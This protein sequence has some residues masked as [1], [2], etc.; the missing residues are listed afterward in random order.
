MEATRFDLEGE[1]AIVTGGGR[2]IGRAC[3]LALSANGANVVVASRTRAEIE[4]V[5]RQ[6]KNEGRESLAVATDVTRKEDVEHLVRR[7]MAEFGAIDILVNNAGIIIVKPIVPTP[8]W[9]PPLA[10]LVSNFNDGFD[11]QDWYRILETN[12]TSIFRCC[13]AVVPHMMAKK[14][15]RIINISSI[16]A[17]HGL[18][19]AAAYCA[20]KGAVKSMTKAL[21]KEWVRY[22]I[23][24][25]CVAPG[26]TDTDLFPPLA[27]DEDLRTSVA[28]QN[29]P[30]RRFAR[31]EEIAVPVVYLA[32]DQASYVTGESF[33]IDGGVLA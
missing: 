14:K 11:D 16:D 29:V 3:A 2:G 18:P 19:F 4:Q 22:N 27:R 33:H 7:S 32:S 23:T 12:L 24:V 6:I 5:S 28:K 13:Q 9:T 8:G 1:T 26:Y 21:A 25:N 15:G 10:G 31:P 30:M 20:N 17:D